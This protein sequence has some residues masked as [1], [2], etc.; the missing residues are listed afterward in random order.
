MLA[1]GLALLT[2]GGR[3]LEMDRPPPAAEKGAAA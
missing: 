1:I 2:G 3:L